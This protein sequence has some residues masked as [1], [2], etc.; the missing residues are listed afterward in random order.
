MS[1]PRT[2]KRA[3][4]SSGGSS[5]SSSS[6]SSSTSAGG[7]SSLLLSLLSGSPVTHDG[8]EPVGRAT[9]V[10]AVEL[11]PSYSGAEATRLLEAVAVAAQVSPPPFKSGSASSASFLFLAPLYPS[12]RSLSVRDVARAWVLA[13][14]LCIDQMAVRRLEDDL[15]Q[16]YA[17]SPGSTEDW[18]AALT[19][20]CG[21]GA[22]H[23]T[24]LS[25]RNYIVSWGKCLHP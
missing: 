13:D 24:T 19:V 7:L 20:V 8:I 4:Q 6:S 21:W 2:A 3:R 17:E 18:R 11:L 15:V 1:A 12:L 16:R 25:L 22:T 14:Y 5:S 9:L 10:E 23:T